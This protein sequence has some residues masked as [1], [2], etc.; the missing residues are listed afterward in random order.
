MLV[1]FNIGTDIPYY[2][3]KIK[4][5]SPISRLVIHE[6]NCSMFMT[7]DTILIFEIQSELVK[8]SKLDLDLGS[9]LKKSNKSREDFRNKGFVMFRN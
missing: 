9:N 4:I 2:V 1:T 7:V 6:V 8:S 3:T 5:L